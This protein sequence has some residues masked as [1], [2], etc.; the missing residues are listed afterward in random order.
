[1]TTPTDPREWSAEQLEQYLHA[2][3]K[4]GDT[5]G[6]GAALTLLSGKDPARAVRL[7]E[8]PKFALRVV[9]VI[10]G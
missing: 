10:R 4:A 9:E 2:A 1:M 3:L 6:V 5:E 8:D 7:Y